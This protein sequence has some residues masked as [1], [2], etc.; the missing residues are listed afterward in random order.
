[1][2][3][4][5]FSSDWRLSHKNILTFKRADGSPLR[6]FNTIEEHDEHIIAQHNSVVRP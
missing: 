5:F 6:V 3:N 1:M 4:I 2:P